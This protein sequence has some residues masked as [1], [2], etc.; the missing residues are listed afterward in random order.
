MVEYVRD[1]RYNCEVVYCLLYPGTVRAAGGGVVIPA[2]S[3]LLL[4]VSVSPHKIISGIVKAPPA[5]G[6]RQS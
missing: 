6:V 2:S 3:A 4:A 1:S 5:A